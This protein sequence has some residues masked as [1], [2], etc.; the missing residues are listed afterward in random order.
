MQTR[1]QIP[2]RL[3]KTIHDSIFQN[4]S[5]PKSNKLYFKLLNLESKK[6]RQDT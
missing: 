6:N 4:N 3:P 1:K 5:S 2:I